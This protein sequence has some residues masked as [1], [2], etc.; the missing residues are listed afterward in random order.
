MNFLSSAFIIFMIV[1][2]ALLCITKQRGN[3]P[4]YIINCKLFVLCLCRLAL[5]RNIID[6]DDNCILHSENH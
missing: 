1:L 5:F 3:T 6:P 2:L 4:N